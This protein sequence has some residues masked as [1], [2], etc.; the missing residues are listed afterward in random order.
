MGV[1]FYIEHFGFNISYI[2][3]YIYTQIHI[4][5]GL[6]GAEQYQPNDKPHTQQLKGRKVKSYYQF[7]RVVK[8]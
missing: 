4:Y 3:I 5:S 2:Y 6:T 8:Q 1:L 7:E